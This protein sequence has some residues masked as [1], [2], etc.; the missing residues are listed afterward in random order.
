MP[1][2]LG[3]AEA[4]GEGKGEERNVQV[5]GWAMLVFTKA[6]PALLFAFSSRFEG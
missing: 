6:L 3:G 5:L 2:R 1:S 4:I